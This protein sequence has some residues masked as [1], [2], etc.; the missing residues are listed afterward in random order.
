M[1]PPECINRNKFNRKKILS[2]GIADV[3]PC[4][5]PPEHLL[6][7]PPPPQTAKRPMSP[8][9]A[10]EWCRHIPTSHF[11]PPIC[12]GKGDGRDERTHGRNAASTQR[13]SICSNGRAIVCVFVDFFP[14]LPQPPESGMGRAHTHDQ[15]RMCN[16]PVRW[17][18]S[19]KKKYKGK[20]KRIG[21]LPLSRVKDVW[22]NKLTAV[23]L[24]G[25]GR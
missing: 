25:D 13:E 17:Q 1:H 3:S 9:P 21:H 10:K 24:L 8:S 4:F 11:L 12:R 23:A 6:A 15:T 18:T 5:L 2:D 20:K 22:S 16:G 19:T 14:P 7:C